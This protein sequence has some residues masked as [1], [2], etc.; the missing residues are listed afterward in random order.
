MNWETITR[1]LLP[2][3]NNK[4]HYRSKQINPK[5]I[6]SKRDPISFRIGLEMRR[7]TKEEASALS[8]A[9]Q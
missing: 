4:V 2:V 9:T 6:H 7:G 1:Y 5:Q 8:T 3:F